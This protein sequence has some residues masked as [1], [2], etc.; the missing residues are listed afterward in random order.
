[1]QKNERVK[2]GIVS[3][4]AAK[5]SH[6]FFR[7][8]QDGDFIVLFARTFSEL[9][10]TNDLWPKKDEE[11]ADGELVPRFQLRTGVGFGPLPL[12]QF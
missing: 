5:N 3:R 4:E 1:L 9:F 2:K 12:A 7:G 8:K 11:L 6:S 10:A